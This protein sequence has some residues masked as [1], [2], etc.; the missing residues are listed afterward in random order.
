[1]KVATLSGEGRGK[2]VPVFNEAPR[3]EDVWGSGGIAPRILKHGTRW[4]WVVR[5]TP[6]IHWIGGWAG[7][8][9]GLDA[10]VKRKIL[11]PCRNWTPVVRPRVIL[12]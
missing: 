2:V 6:G 11:S 12:H 3:H 10:V 7:P 4:R 5:F 9:A 8:G 1:V